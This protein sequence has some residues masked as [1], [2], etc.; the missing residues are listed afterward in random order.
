[1]KLTMIFIAMIVQGMLIAM[2]LRKIGAEIKF[3][4][5]IKKLY[6]NIK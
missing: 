1:M 6:S 2:I 5:K 4:E 3:T